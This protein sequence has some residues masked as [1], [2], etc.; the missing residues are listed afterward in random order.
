MLYEVITLI[1]AHFPKP[2]RKEVHQKLLAL[3]KPGG[4]ILFEAFSKEQLEYSSGGPKNIEMLFSSEE[5][6]DEFP[7]VTF[8][9][10]EKKKIVLSEGKY[11]QGEGSVIR[12]LAVKK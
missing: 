6:K 5:V 11:H 4:K 8:E 10:L 7:G 9:L 3:L 2:I 12:F 1:F